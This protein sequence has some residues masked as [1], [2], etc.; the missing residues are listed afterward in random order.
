MQKNIIRLKLLTTILIFLSTLCSAQNKATGLEFLPEDQYA[1]IP[2]A[3]TAMMGTLP[4]SKD[5]SNWFPTPGDQG[6]QG[7]CV[8]WAVAY[9]L[10][11]YEEAVERRQTPNSSSLVFSPSFMYNQIKLSDCMNGAYIVTALNFLKKEGIVSLQQFPYHQ[12]DCSRLPN[13]FEKK[14]AGM[15]AIA[16]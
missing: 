6:N 1:K 11:S 7:S 14:S 13:S 9:G 8:A 3:S 4:V 10:K 12:Y 15:Y 16:D 2:L 5:L